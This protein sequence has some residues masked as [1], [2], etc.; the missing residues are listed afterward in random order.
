M[1]LLGVG[2]V[3][4]AGVFVLTGIAA[5][6]SGPSV[7]V[8]YMLAAF[9]AF[10]SGLCFLEFSVSVPVAGAAYT[11]VNLVF[12]ELPAWIVACN[13]TLEYTLA[14]AAV[15]RSFTSYLATLVGKPS[16][17]F[18]VPAGPLKLDF[19][20]VAITLMCAA[21]LAA[22]TKETAAFNSAVCVVHIVVIA[23]IIFA[24][25]NDGL[26]GRGARRVGRRTPH[27]HPAVE[28]NKWGAHAA[29]Q[30]PT[31]R[32]PATCRRAIRERT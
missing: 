19:P 27:H 2:S 3:V 30:P 32:Q 13:R 14:I 10:L 16:T 23:Y 26:D 9:S 24:G 22:G 25:E 5:R 12:G 20:A 1:T 8:S 15:A 17:A 6:I 7:A 11:Y 18:L 31:T 29:A 4:G 21:L 28:G